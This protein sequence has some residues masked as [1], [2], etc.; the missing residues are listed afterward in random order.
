MA[1]IVRPRRMLLML[2]TWKVKGGCV[3]K[4]CKHLGSWLPAIHK[5]PK[6]SPLHFCANGKEHKAFLTIQ[7]KREKQKR[8]KI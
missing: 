5:L 2:G 6:P 8:K 7:V 4:K 1:K 3:V